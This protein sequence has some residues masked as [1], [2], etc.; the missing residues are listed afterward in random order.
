MVSSAPSPHPTLSTL[1]LETCE[2]IYGC[3]GDE[4]VYLSTEHPQG[5]GT[6]CPPDRR[7]LHTTKDCPV[8]NANAPARE[9]LELFGFAT[10]LSSGSLR[11]DLAFIMR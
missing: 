7:R 9:T 6:K 8:W 1:V 2:D 10:I 11:R 4:G 5:V 3:R